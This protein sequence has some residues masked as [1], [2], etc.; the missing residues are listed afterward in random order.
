[1]SVYTFKRR[2]DTNE[3]HIFEG[4]YADNGVNCTV[5]R[6]SICRGMNQTDG[7]SLRTYTIEDQ[8]QIFCSCNEE[9]VARLN[10]AKIGREVCGTC[11]SHLYESY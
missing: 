10:A 6:L 7:E 1:M 11:V 9:D 2:R 4:E 8:T 3:I 5:P